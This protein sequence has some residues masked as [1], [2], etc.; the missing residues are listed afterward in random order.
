MFDKE[1]RRLLSRKLD[2]AKTRLTNDE[3]EKLFELFNRT[4]LQGIQY[5][6]QHSFTGTYSGGKY[7]R[8]EKKTYTVV[9]DE[10]GFGVVETCDIKDD[11]GYFR[12]DT[13]RHTNGRDIL[14]N[15]PVDEMIRLN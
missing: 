10:F 5:T 4:E 9:S 6:K 1:K 8:M 13:I 11:D 3:G 15:V 7:T 12:S 14:R 2:L